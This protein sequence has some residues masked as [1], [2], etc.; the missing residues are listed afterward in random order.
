[1][2]IIRFDAITA[3][4]FAVHRRNYHGNKSDITVP[5][6]SP[7]EPKTFR[8]HF[9]ETIFRLNSHW[10]PYI[11]GQHVDTSGAEHTRFMIKLSVEYGW[12]GQNQNLSQRAES[13]QKVCFVWHHNR[14]L[15]L[16]IRKISRDLYQ[17]KK[18][19]QIALYFN[20]AN[21]CIIIIFFPI[22]FCLW[23]RYK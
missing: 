23:L 3:S 13:G 20:N 15:K 11:Y 17:K 21:T 1:M 6:G 19:N 4:A 22:P 9:G 2:G 14:T 8:F 12:R 16:L 7:I 5:D 10:N 18:C